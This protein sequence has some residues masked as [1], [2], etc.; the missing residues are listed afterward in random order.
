MLTTIQ[1]SECAYCSTLDN[2]ICGVQCAIPVAWACVSIGIIVA[3]FLPTCYVH[4]TVHSKD[5][6]Q[7]KEIIQ[8]WGEMFMWF[9]L[10]VGLGL[11]I[12]LSIWLAFG[13]TDQDPKAGMFA[14][15]SSG[16]KNGFGWFL[17]VV[18]ILYTFLSPCLAA[19][20]LSQT[21][22]D[23]ERALDGYQ[24]LASHLLVPWIGVYIM[25]GT[26]VFWDLGT[27]APFKWRGWVWIFITLSA[28]LPLLVLFFPVRVYRIKQRLEHGT[29]PQAALESHSKM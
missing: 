21:L 19:G 10:V 29:E 1:R 14:E 11:G 24:I 28:A 2:V 27:D 3:L 16:W 15:H 6:D 9:N 5:W 17:D 13:R 22:D 18:I 4:C 8:Y 26:F 12:F 25:A 7:L 20:F 23:Y